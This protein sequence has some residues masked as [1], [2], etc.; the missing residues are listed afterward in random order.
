MLDRIRTIL[1][2]DKRACL[3]IFFLVLQAN[4]KQYYDLFR[5]FCVM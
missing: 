1:F 4:D 5:P 3:W 2:T